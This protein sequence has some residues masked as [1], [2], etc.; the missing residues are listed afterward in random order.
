MTTQRRALRAW[1]YL[2]R[3]PSRLYRVL[4]GVF[5]RVVAA[6][7]RRPPLINWN[8]A[9]ESRLPHWLLGLVV[10]FSLQVREA[11]ASI[12]GAVLVNQ[13][14]ALARRVGAYMLAWHRANA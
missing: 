7:E 12:P 13:P 3:A 1:N 14:Q 11:P 4:A 5:L 10:W 9:M 8:S 6:G 2:Q